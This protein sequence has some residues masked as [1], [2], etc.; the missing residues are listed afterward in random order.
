MMTFASRAMT[1]AR[2]ALVLALAVSVAVGCGGRTYDDLPRDMKQVMVTSTPG[3]GSPLPSSGTWSWM[4]G[5]GVSLSN[6]GLDGRFAES[7]IRDAIEVELAKRGWNR[8]GS[9]SDVMVGYVAAL[10]EEMSDVDLIRRFGLSPGMPSAGAPYGKGSLV[11]VLSKPGATAPV[12]RGAAQILADFELS[13]EVREQRIR[14][15]VNVLM[16]SIPMR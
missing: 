13:D 10:S 3:P 5:S 7:V 14:N 16:S 2:P 1:C 15:G 6:P 11:V 9:G 12:W 8:G 4:P